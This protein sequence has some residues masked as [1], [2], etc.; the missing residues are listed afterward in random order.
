MALKRQFFPITGGEKR[1]HALL[2][3]YRK[4]ARSGSMLQRITLLRKILQ[5]LPNSPR[6]R[7]DL[8]TAERSRCQ[9]IEHEL[10]QI[11]GDSD[12]C[13]RLEELC[14]EVMAPD[15]LVPPKDELKSAIRQK[16]RPLQQARLNKE[17][18]SKLAQLQECYQARDID[19]LENEFEKWKA[20]C[21]NPVVNLSDEQR[22]TAADI[23][24]FLKQEAETRRNE[25]IFQELIRKIEQKLAD[26]APFPAVAGDYNQLQLMDNPIPAVLDDRL[27]AL[28]EEYNHLEH[29]RHVRWCIYGVCGAVMLILA[30]GFSIRYM[31]HYLAVNHNLANMKKHLADKKYDEVIKIYGEL[32]AASSKVAADPQIIRIHTEAKQ[33]KE[34]LLRHQKMKEEE[35]KRLL[36]QIE[37]LSETDVLDNAEQLTKTISD[38]ENLKGKETL[39]KESLDRFTSLKTKVIQKR[40]ELK[41][42]R[43]AEFRAFCSKKIGEVDQLIKQIRDPQKKLNDLKTL[44]ET[45]EKGF[46]EHLKS[47]RYHYIVQALKDEEKQKYQSAKERFKQTWENENAFRLVGYPESFDDYLLALDRIRYKYPD[48]AVRYSLA[49]RFCE[50]WK[51]ERDNYE[52]D[53]PEK[54]EGYPEN[55]G[56]TDGLFK[57]DLAKFRPKTE[58]SKRFDQFFKD[59]QIDKDLKEIIF[60]DADGRP[61]YFYF[62]EKDGRI[63]YLRNP[64]RTNISFAALPVGKEKNTRFIITYDDKNKPEMPYLIKTLPP[65]LP[66]QLPE[67]FTLLNGQKKPPIPK[68]GLPFWPGHALSSDYIAL[69]SDGLGLISNLKGALRFICREGAVENIYLKHIFLQKFLQELYDVSRGLYPEVGEK[70]EELKEVIP[71]NWRVPQ[72]FPDYVNMKK[73]FDL[74]WSLANLNRLLAAGELRERFLCKAHARRFIPVGV[75]QN[76]EPGKVKIHL[77]KDCKLPAEGLVLENNAVFILPKEVRQGKVPRDDKWKKRL[78]TGQVVWRYDDGLSTREF[79]RKWKEEAQRLNIELKVKPSVLPADVVL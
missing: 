49:L 66:Y 38:A 79:L 14:R 11:T 69:N 76:A 15:W 9:E 75:I 28:E 37:R 8:I 35:F 5:K 59:I 3:D 7:N 30:I 45:N 23:E 25:Q 29:L 22:Q 39:S 73:E 77:F 40:T 72:A 21:A 62:H 10:E 13:S 68:D 50:K 57:T 58:R 27:K 48:L 63:E 31:Q 55:N 17:I 65:N 34:E 46:D 20:L 54:L 78:F 16:L 36:Q 60:T 67:G 6:W 1:L 71:F 44:M 64:R 2:Q 51:K 70:L 43:E 24:S 41:N 12:S 33:E 74:K 52:K 4:I 53:F 42:R 26:N 32:K 61:F 18:E 19:R 56:F 47:S